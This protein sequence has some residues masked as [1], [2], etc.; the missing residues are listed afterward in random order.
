M[1][2]AGRPDRSHADELA[3]IESLDNGKPVRLAKFV[4]VARTVAHFR[5]FAGWPTKIEGSVVPTGHGDRRAARPDRGDP[6][7]RVAPI[8][9]AILN[10]TASRPPRF[11]TIRKSCGP[12]RRATS[13]S[14]ARRSWTARSSSASGTAR[15]PRSTWRRAPCDG[16]TRPAVL[17]ANRHRPSPAALCTSAT[18]TARSTPSARKMASAAGRSKP[19]GRSNP[20]PVVANGLV[21]FGSSDTASL[22]A[23][24]PRGPAEVEIPNSRSRARARPRCPAVWRS[25]P[26]ATACSARSGWRT[27]LRRTGLLIGSYHRGV[28]GG[29]RRSRVCGDLRRRSA[30]DMFSSRNPAILARAKDLFARCFLLDC[31]P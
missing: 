3:E 28:S 18:S 16:S 8:P 9:R 26:V 15:S 1:Q 30:G 31:F 17:S 4:D 11:P 21:L 12:T 27:V 10:S 14:R 5:Y 7:E 24:R 19:A 22:R 6:G 2:R 23:R 25:S 20:S 13:S 29:L